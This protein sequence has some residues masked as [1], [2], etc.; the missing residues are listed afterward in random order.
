MKIDKLDFLSIK[1][2][3]LQKTPLRKWNYKPNTR[4]FIKLH[5]TKD[6]E[7]K[8]IITAQQYKVKQHNVNEQKTWTK[9]TLKRHKTNKQAHEKTLSTISQLEKCKLKAQ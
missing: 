3:V 5:L 6:L 4:M 1:T 2:F 8:W 7:Q 9:A